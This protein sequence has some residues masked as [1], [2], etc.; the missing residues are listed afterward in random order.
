MSRARSTSMKARRLTDRQ[1]ETLDAIRQHIRRHGQSP[2]RAELGAALGLTNQSA[3]DTHLQALARK[4]WIVLEAST[5]R[6]IKILDDNTPIHHLDEVPIVSA[7]TP[8]LAEDG[9]P[10]ARMKTLQTLWNRFER[11]PDYFVVVEGDSMSAVGLR[12]GDLVA[13]RRDPDPRDGD[14]VIAR[15]EAEITLKRFH[16]TEN[17]VELHP[18]ST[19]AEHDVM[20]VDPETDFEVVGIVVGAVI[21]PPR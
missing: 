5:R 2:S 20:Q 15:I 7:G 13:V 8:K 6:G 10:Q 11:T 1:A 14:I 18:E 12:S 3:V 19:N 4:S 9:Q 16:R 21:G 17:G